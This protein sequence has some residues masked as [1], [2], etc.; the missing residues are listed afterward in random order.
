MSGMRGAAIARAAVNRRASTLLDLVQSVQH[1]VA[2]DTE[3][4]TIVTWLINTGA[5]VLT[6]SF[7][8][9]RI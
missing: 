3:V 2:S 1:Q 7:A 9:Q 4:V 6:G 5:V 8:G